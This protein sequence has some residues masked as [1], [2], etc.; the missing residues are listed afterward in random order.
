MSTSEG[1]LPLLDQQLVRDAFV[2]DRVRKAGVV[3]LGHANLA[4][5]AD[6][7]GQS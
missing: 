2:V 4:K 3:I 5:N 7:R 6:H 1:G